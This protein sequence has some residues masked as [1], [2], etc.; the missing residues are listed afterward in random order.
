MHKSLAERLEE[1]ISS[2]EEALTQIEQQRNAQALG[3]GDLGGSV[4]DPS[5]RSRPASFLNGLIG[6]VRCSSLTGST[7]GIVAKFEKGRGIGWTGPH[8]NPASAGAR[9]RGLSQSL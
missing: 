7:A 4:A 6:P 3:R 5:L 9:P 2:I 1:R 8:S